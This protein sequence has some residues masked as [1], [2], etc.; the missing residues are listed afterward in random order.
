MK[1]KKKTG[2]FTEINYS[3]G[4]RKFI[5]KVGIA[6]ITMSAFSVISLS[7]FSCS[8]SVSPG[9]DFNIGGYG[10]FKY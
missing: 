7:S 2:K 5:K 8:D 9:S 10:Y 1:N 6:T 4:R 3:P